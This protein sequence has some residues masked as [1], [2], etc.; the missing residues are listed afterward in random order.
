MQTEFQTELF[1]AVFQHS[2]VRGVMAAVDV[3]KQRF[4][5]TSV[6]G[7]V[8]VSEKPINFRKRRH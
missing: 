4:S 8:S 3:A 1:F 6:C 2:Y 7:I 5:V